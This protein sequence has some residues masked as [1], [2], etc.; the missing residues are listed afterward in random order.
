MIL[1][2]S[3]TN[4]HT[5]TNKTCTIR[6]SSFPFFV[7]SDVFNVSFQNV[8][9]NLSLSFLLKY[10]DTELGAVPTHTLGVADELDHLCQ[11]PGNL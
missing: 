9:S 2:R 6:E 8:S 1:G 10:F 11:A 7:T 3:H 5:N 4:T